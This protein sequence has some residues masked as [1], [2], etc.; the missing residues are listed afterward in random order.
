MRS[1]LFINGSRPIYLRILCAFALAVLVGFAAH[2]GKF[3][4]ADNALRLAS[5]DLSQRPASGQ[6]H[7]VEMDAASVEAIREWPWSRSHYA[8][9]VDQLDVAGV[10]SIVFDVDFSSH[11]GGP[12]DAEFASAIHR[13]NSPV[14]LPAFS[15][16]SN[17]QSHEQLDALP[18][19]ELREHAQLA[20][21]SI[22]PD[23]DGFIRRMPFGT[24]S[25]D[26]PRPSLSSYL[27]GKGGSA[28][29]HFPIDFGIDVSSIPRHSFIDIKRGDFDPSKLRG[30]DVLIG[31]TAIEMGDRYAVP[32][33]GVTLGVF[34]QALAGETLLRGEPRYGSWAF[35]LTLAAILGVLVLAA[36]TYLATGV[37]A[38]GALAL[39]MG[40]WYFAY[41]SYHIWFEIAP[42]LALILLVAAGRILVIARKAYE[43]ARR[44]DR[45]TD[46]PNGL[47]LRDQ[48]TDQDDGFV[49]A[50]AIDDIAA[51]KAV[52]GAEDFPRLI[53]RIVER[54]SVSTDRARVHRIDNRT[55]AWY[56]AMQLDEV[57]ELSSG[58]QAIMRAPIEI[59]GRRVD[60][61]LALGV[62][63]ASQ[64]KCIENASHAA[65]EALHKGVTWRVFEADNELQLE[66]QISLM[67]ELDDALREGHMSVFYQ[68]K[69][70]LKSGD[71][72]CAEAL[73]R[74]EHPEKG[75]LPPDS[76]IPLAEESG[77]VEDFTL[78]VVRKTIED[79]GQ[80]CERG[81]VLGAAVNISARLLTSKSFV[82]RVEQLIDDLGAP[83]NRLTFEVTESAELEDPKAAIATLNRFK[84]R[85]I[86][87]SMD[88][89]GTGQS[90]LN[91]LK[92]LPLS[93]LKID[94]SFV[95]NA[96]TDRNDAML[97]RS[98]VQ[99]AHELGLKV[100]AEG[101]EEAECLD[102][103]KSIDCDF[104]QGYFIGKPMRADELAKLA[105][106]LEHIAA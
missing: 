4:F 48:I 53:R 47:A 26:T 61:S 3:L 11:S 31:A 15:R 91:Y 76:F 30:K 83:N 23:G 104:A 2:T 51:L 29:A 68:P 16:S 63:D 35:P 27:A 64:A 65:A 96:H 40:V 90:T 106:R 34:V 60:I 32:R 38:L 78:F 20:S 41:Q 101:I 28:D 5:F 56:C 1:S 18:I 54:L 50:A 44:T 92:Q 33:Y 89:Y 93:E 72:T 25:A 99:L 58:L 69:M 7:V 14:V 98:T 57:E 80:W 102:F 75:M 49:I 21:V 6:I 9:L 8:Q 74:W 82:A 13:A 39:L 17:Y 105:G 55:L 84:E 43:L 85:G 81:L 66:R 88:D 37:R 62:A 46:L 45:D 24:I 79:M 59:A 77:R 52:L 36:K 97:V 95:Q 71:I 94:R 86:A 87:I 67:G 42:A 12:G 22:A 19:P 70:E 103:L 100:V 73:I 10:R